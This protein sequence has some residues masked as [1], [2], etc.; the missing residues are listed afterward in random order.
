MTSALTYKEFRETIGIAALGL[1]ALLVVAAANMGW[2]FVVSWQTHASIPFL[3]DGFF[4][5]F[6]FLAAAL[7]IA[8]GLRQTLGDFFGDAYLF[9]L[10]RPVGRRQIFA[11]KLLVGLSLYAVGAAVPMLLY[12]WWASLPGTHASPFEWSMTSDAWVACF[13]ISVIYLGAFLS[14]IRPGAWLGTRLMPLAGA[15]VVPVLITVLPW[16]AAVAVVA[17][18][19]ALLISLILFVGETR[20]FA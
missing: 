2:V 7:A 1:A 12:A 4:T 6:V 18:V 15:L 13:S 11:A 20:D 9:L 19:D 8:L 5:P 17:A 10:H 16:S 3:S 14:G